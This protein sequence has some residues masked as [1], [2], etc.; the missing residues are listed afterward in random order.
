MNNEDDRSLVWKEQSRKIL[1]DTVVFK[2][3]ERTSISPDGS[4]GKYIVNEAKDWAIVIPV[5]KENFLMVRQ[6]RHGEQKLSIEFPGGVIEE[7]ESPEK[8]ASRELMEETG[9]TAGK[10]TF[11]GSMNPN[12]ALFSN[13]VFIY[14]AEQLSFSG[15]QKLDSDEYVHY[16]EKPQAEVSEKM[17]T[18][19]YCHALMATALALYIHHCTKKSTPES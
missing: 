14:C 3:T 10:L 5:E 16:E 19:E 12:P 18:G 2:V 6:W 11:L 17:G 7:G 9:C 13:H 15:K 1:L 4:L 8:A